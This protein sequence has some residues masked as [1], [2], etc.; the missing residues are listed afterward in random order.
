M[1][2]IHTNIKSLIKKLEMLSSKEKID[3]WWNDKN[4]QNLLNKYRN[5]YCFYNKEKLKNLK[6]L[7]ASV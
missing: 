2:I 7:I 3:I 6:E 1:G 4:K 5:D